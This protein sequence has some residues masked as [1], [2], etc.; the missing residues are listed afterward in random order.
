MV[1]GL[2]IVQECVTS[3]YKYYTYWRHTAAT[4]YQICR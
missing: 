2:V 3:I 1:H 4:R